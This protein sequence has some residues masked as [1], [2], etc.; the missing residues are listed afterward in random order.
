MNPSNRRIA[1]SGRRT[2]LAVALA[3]GAPAAAVVPLTLFA[4]P[5]A[6]A[7]AED[8]EGGDGEE[9]PEVLEAKLREQMDKI[10]KL[11]R[12][13]EQAI[14]AASAGSGKK[15]VGPEVETPDAPES[16]KPPP[17][18]APPKA[19]GS[20]GGETPGSKGDDIKKRMEELIRATQEQ[21]GSIPKELEELV[22]MIPTMGGGGGGG[23]GSDPSGMGNSPQKRDLP[24]PDD[25]QSKKDK[26]GNP[27]S[28]DKERDKPDGSGKPPS[29]S[30]TGEPPHNDD[31]LWQTDLPEELRKA[32][33]SGKVED[34]PARLRPLLER[35]LKWLATHAKSRH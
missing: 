27:K 20:G 17:R 29:K 16:S 9:G 22:K 24:D 8:G 21:G 33:L 2:A 14:L 26:D 12:E 4:L 6:S 30:E 1:S 11:M 31:P 23:G 3:L 15:P 13:N 10:L 18:N 25:P 19:D 35:Y 32:I 7:R 5:A 28:G 34:A